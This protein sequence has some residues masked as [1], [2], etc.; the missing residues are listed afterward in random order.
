MPFLNAFDHEIDHWLTIIKVRK[1]QPIPNPPHNR[2]VMVSRRR[3]PR[4]DRKTNGP[5]K[6]SNVIQGLLT[7]CAQRHKARRQRLRAA[8]KTNDQT[9]SNRSS[10]G[11][12][13]LKLLSDIILVVIENA[14][15]M[16]MLTLVFGQTMLAY[17]AAKPN[18]SRFLKFKPLIQIS[19]K[20]SKSNKKWTANTKGK[21]ASQRCAN[22]QSWLDTT[23]S[24]NER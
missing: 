19:K 17:L 24:E 21:I 10:R 3:K 1:A 4:M 5:L 16:A 23:I 9:K 12:A 6:H 11:R 18:K 7:L 2:I 15:D 22:T 8:I 20:E 14:Y 13:M